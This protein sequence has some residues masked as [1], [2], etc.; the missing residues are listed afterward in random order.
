MAEW[1]VRVSAAGKIVEGKET[2]RWP[3][4]CVCCGG[5]PDD[6]LEVSYSF[7]KVLGPYYVRRSWSV[8]YCKM[9]REHFKYGGGAPVTFWVLSA[10]LGIMALLALF[11][12]L[13]GGIQ[14]REL[15]RD[16]WVGVALA[17]FLAAFSAGMILLGRRA[18]SR[19]KATMKE[20]CASARS[21]VRYAGMGAEPIP[22]VHT[23]VFYFKSR[24]Y[25]EAFARANGATPEFLV[26]D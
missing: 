13:V 8:P 9:C 20:T 15:S 23:H 19:L 25:G 10:V 18:R 26:S 16:V 21:P 12:A 22:G 4:Q 5:T 11:E 17:A 2:L 6:Q 1:Q 24:A 14:A 7:G 3:Q